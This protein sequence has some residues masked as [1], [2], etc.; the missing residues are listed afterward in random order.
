MFALP[1]ERRR[2]W[3]YDDPSGVPETRSPSP[4]EPV[5][6]DEPKRGKVVA[7]PVARRPHRRPPKAA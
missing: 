3:V 1:S 5:A 7:L 4:A 6:A 2:H